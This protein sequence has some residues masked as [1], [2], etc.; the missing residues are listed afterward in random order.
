MGLPARHDAGRGRA[1][2][3]GCRLTL[4]HHAVPTIRSLEREHMRLWVW[5][6]T[7]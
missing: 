7:T 5:N 4:P 2:G 1:E 6:T 3:V